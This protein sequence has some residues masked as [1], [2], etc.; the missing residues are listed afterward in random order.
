MVRVCWKLAKALVNYF[1]EQSFCI[2]KGTY[3]QLA[4]HWFWKSDHLDYTKLEFKT[5]FLHLHRH[6]AKIPH[7][8]S[9][10]LLCK[11]CKKLKLIHSWKFYIKWELMIPKLFAQSF[12]KG[13]HQLCHHKLSNSWLDILLHLILLKQIKNLAIHFIL[14]KNWFTYLEGLKDKLNCLD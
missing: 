10:W 12:K 8:L 14:Y 7:L 11:I 1:Q 3:Q 13:L 9:F 5:A 2:N 4:A 6:L